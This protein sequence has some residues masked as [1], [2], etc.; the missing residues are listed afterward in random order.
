[1]R[2]LVPAF[3]LLVAGCATAPQ[4]PAP[5]P[6]TAAHPP[7]IA[8]GLIGASAADLVGHFGNPALQVRE[9][10]GLKL[11]F[12]SQRCVLDAYLYVPPGGGIERVAHIDARLPSGV[13]ADQAACVSA[14]ESRN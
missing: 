1:M 14:L 7:R 2:R 11:Q 12:R 5:Q 8:A 13:D 6:V 3:A 9:G 4:E 10:A